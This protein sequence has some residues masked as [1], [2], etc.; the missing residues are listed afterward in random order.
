MKSI[1]EATESLLLSKTKYVTKRPINTEAI[2]P[3][4]ETCP[5]DLII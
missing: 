5:T 4:F 2:S 1:W 3:L